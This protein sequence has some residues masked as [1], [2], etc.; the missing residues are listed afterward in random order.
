MSA[1]ATLI[2]GLSNTGKS[3]YSVNV[4]GQ[5]SF[6]KYVVNGNPDQFPANYEHID[7]EGLVGI[8]NA[9]V[10]IE[11]L[12][13]PTDAEF[14]MLQNLL[15]KLKRHNNIFCHVLA[16]AIE[17]NNLHSLLQHFDFVVFTHSSKNLSVFKTYVSRHCTQDLET[18]MHTWNHFLSEASKTHYLVYNVAKGLWSTVDEKGLELD[19]PETELRNRVLQFVRPFSSPEE[20]MALFDFL[21]GCLPIGSLDKKDMIISVREGAGKNALSVS[22]LDIIGYCTDKNSRKPPNDDII[23]VFK[24]LQNMYGIPYLFIMNK[25]FM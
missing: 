8:E 16:H 7:Y 22:L 23:K 21:I 24:L 13:R 9:F 11:D 1:T 10:I 17:K 2:L 6:P 18:A 19:S 12:V 4:S 15:V 20:S 3:T 14:K 5:Y 25:H